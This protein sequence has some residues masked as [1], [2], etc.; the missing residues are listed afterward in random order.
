VAGR[1]TW[2]VSPVA[3][4]RL[5]DQLSMDRE[6]AG[7]RLPLLCTLGWSDLRCQKLNGVLV[8]ACCTLRWYKCTGRVVVFVLD[9]IALVVCWYVLEAP[10]SKWRRK[11]SKKKSGEEIEI[12]SSAEAPSLCHQILKLSKV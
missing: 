4:V 1:L 12:S 6:P 10:Y 3:A 5:A 9:L 7:R 2:T 11:F 8:V